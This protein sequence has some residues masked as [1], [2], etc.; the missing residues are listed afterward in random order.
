MNLKNIEKFTTQGRQ[1]KRENAIRAMEGKINPF[2]NTAVGQAGRSSLGLQ[3]YR[4]TE[5]PTRAPV[6]AN[7]ARGT[8]SSAIYNPA[9]GQFWLLDNL[10]VTM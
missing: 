6:T 5:M 3:R 7:K 4:N 1:E 9:T 2:A 10:P 8:G